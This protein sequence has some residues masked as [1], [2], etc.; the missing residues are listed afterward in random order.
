MAPHQTYP[1]PR[2]DREDG[3][4]VG[5]GEAGHGEV[6]PL[7]RTC[8]GGLLAAAASEVVAAAPGPDLHDTRL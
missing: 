6:S 7:C 3:L 5:A 2:H 1:Q 4:A 8:A